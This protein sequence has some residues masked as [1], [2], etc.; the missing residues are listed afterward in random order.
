MPQTHIH[1]YLLAIHIYS[2]LYTFAPS[3]CHLRLNVLRDTISR[4]ADVP[5]TCLTPPTAVNFSHYVAPLLPHLK[6]FAIISPYCPCM[7]SRLLIAFHGASC[8]RQN[9]LSKL[10]NKSFKKNKTQ[11]SH[12]RTHTNAYTHI[13]M[14]MLASGNL[15]EASSNKKNCKKLKEAKL[16]M[17]FEMICA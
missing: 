9:E 13:Q 16:T 17:L 11:S 15:R 12:T 5:V 8:Q 2:N 7:F 10:S 1:T 4:K 6:I 14:Q 3:I